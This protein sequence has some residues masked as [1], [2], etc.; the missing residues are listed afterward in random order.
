VPSRTRANHLGSGGEPSS[1]S[2][3][4]HL[5]VHRIRDPA[6]ETPQRFEL[7]LPGGELASVVDTAGVSMRIW[8]IAAM[9]IM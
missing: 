7:G 3:S 2:V 4:E 8:L 9:W 5:A 1:F 6:L